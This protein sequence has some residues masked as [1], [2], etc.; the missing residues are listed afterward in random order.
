M[1]EEIHK[2]AAAEVAVVAAAVAAV[3]EEHM[4]CTVAGKEETADLPAQWPNMGRPANRQMRYKLNS[5]LDRPENHRLMLQA[6]EG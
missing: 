5:V 2:R 6:L 1:D 4:Q 3:V